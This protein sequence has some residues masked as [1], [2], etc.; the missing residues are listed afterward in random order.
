MSIALNWERYYEDFHEGL[1]TTYERVILHHYFES[2]MKRFSINSVLE[3]PSFGMTG[4][5][6]INSMWWAP[7]GVRVTVMDDNLNRIGLIAEV[8]D[9]VPLKAD[10]VFTESFNCLPF[11]NDSFDLGWNFAA[12]WFIDNTRLFLQE[13]TRVTRKVIFICV[14]NQSGIAHMFGSKL[15]RNQSQ[16]VFIDNIKPQNISSAMESL[17]WQIDGQGYFDVPPWPDIAMKKEDLLNRIGLN[18]LSN[19]LKHNNE[20]Y[21]CILDY[22]NGK[23]EH[24]EKEILRYS[25]LERSPLFFKKLWAHHMYFIFTPKTQT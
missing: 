25:F 1:G 23:N 6:G 5:S 3:A 21:L 11:D 22:F 12:L 9:E 24:M 20:N 13:L 16:N 2:L 18:R 10:F 17:D 8:W 7:R 14:P 19:R 15:V 4:I